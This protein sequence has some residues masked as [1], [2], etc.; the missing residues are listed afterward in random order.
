MDIDFLPFQIG[1]HYEHWEFD[2]EPINGS[3]EYD[4][5]VY[6][7]SDITKLSGVEVT[8]IYLYFSCDI[9]FRVEVC[10]SAME[11]SLQEKVDII[12]YGLDINYVNN[13]IVLTLG[14]T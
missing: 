7:G 4:K 12:N 9:L 11:L 13:R 8:V 3:W 10:L 5:Y 1:M 14:Q 6:I 2:L